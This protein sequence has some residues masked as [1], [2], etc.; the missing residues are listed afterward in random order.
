VDEFDLIRRYFEPLGPSGGAL[1]LGIGDDCALLDVPAGQQLA[2]ST[3]TLVE[4]RHFTAAVDPAAL[5]HKALAVNLSDLAAMG[6]QP[7]AYTLALT[8]PERDPQWLSGLV[9]GLA[10]LAAASGIV[11]AGGDTTAGPLS[12]TLTVMGAVPPDQA[13]R[14]SGARP[15][16]LI[17]VSGTLGDAAYALHHPGADAGLDARLHRPTPRLALGLAMRQLASAAIDISDGLAGDLGHILRAS[18]VGAELE[19]D[20]LPTSAALARL[21]AVEPRLQAQLHGGDDYELCLCIPPQRWAEAQARA[22]VLE[23]PLTQ[24]GSITAE[25]GLRL[26]RGSGAPHTIPTRGYLHFS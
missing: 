24:V 4:G 10:A 1:T 17:A 16:D 3:D 20:A 2:V 12:L 23:L 5:G 14:R 6:A 18:A 26:R 19:A 15:G 22:A 25:P 13:L 9:S 8:L 7:L 11:L 21:S